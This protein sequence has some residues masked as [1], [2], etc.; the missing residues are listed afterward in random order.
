LPWNVKHKGDWMPYQMIWK[1]F[2]VTKNFK[3]QPVKAISSIWTPKA[4]QFPRRRR[5]RRRRCRWILWKGVRVQQIWPGLPPWCNR[6]KESWNNVENS[7]NNKQNTTTV[8]ND[9]P[10]RSLIPANHSVASHPLLCIDPQMFTCWKTP[11]YVNTRGKEIGELLM[12]WFVYYFWSRKRMK[13]D[14]IWLVSFVIFF[15]MAV[16][17]CF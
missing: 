7:G 9:L 4:I 8:T 14:L 5:R 13:R 15:W 16:E 2:K 6:P 17:D 10:T 12:C 11:G 1:N 3:R